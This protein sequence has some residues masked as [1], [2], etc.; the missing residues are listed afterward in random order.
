MFFYGPSEYSK[1]IY[2][3]LWS[4]GNIELIWYIFPVLVYCIKRNLA[5]L[6]GGSASTNGFRQSGSHVNGRYFFASLAA[7]V[8]GQ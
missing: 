3:T 5:S 4:L 7:F 6:I 2:Y 1:A 8:N